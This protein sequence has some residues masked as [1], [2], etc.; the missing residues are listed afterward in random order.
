[1]S[2]TSAL[3]L[4]RYPRIHSGI[5]NP[6]PK[7][8]PAAKDLLSRMLTPDPAKRITVPEVRLRNLYWTPQP[9]WEPP[10]QLHIL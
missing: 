9:V 10:S 8:S 7:A 2:D 4:L 1:M 3:L 6:I 5:T